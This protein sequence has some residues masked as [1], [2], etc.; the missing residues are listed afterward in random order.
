MPPSTTSPL[1]RFSLPRME[2]RMLR[3]CSWISSMHEV[4]VPALLQ[5]L[6]VHLQ[7][8]DEGRLHLV[9]DVAD[10]EPFP[11]VDAAISPSSR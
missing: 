10:L 3:G 8:L 9:L 4:V 1:A 11:A 5:R 7:L 6:Q 2:S